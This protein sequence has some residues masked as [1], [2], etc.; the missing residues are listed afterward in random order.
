VF[1]TADL[2]LHW[3]TGFLPF[4]KADL[5]RFQRVPWWVHTL[6]LG[7]LFVLLVVAFTTC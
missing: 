6:L 1:I 7:P 3:W 4:R 5:Q 2:A